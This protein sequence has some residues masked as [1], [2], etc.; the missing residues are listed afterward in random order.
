MTRTNGTVRD[1]DTAGKSDADDEAPDARGDASRI[2][3]GADHTLSDAMDADTAT[4]SERRR[5]ALRAL[6][7]SGGQA[8]VDERRQAFRSLDDG[9]G[10]SPETR[11]VLSTM[12]VR[13]AT[14]ILRRPGVAARAGDESTVETV[15][16]LFDLPE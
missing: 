14:R 1:D 9:T 2:E 15:A 3:T 16:A 4:G 12:A 8:V 7:A 6:A 13:I 11:R 10:V 5:E